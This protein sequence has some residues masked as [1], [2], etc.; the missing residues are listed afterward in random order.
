LLQRTVRRS[1]S[2]FVIAGLVLAASGCASASATPTPGDSTEA[3]PTPTSGGLADPN[4]APLPSA[5]AGVNDFL[6][7]LQD[8]DLDAVGA[9]AYDLVVM[10]YSSDGR[11]T[12]EFTREQVSALRNSPGGPKILLAYLSIGEAEDYRYY[13]QSD[14]EEGNPAWLE[15]ENP[16]WPGNLKVRYWEPGWQS[17]VFDYAGRILAAGFDGAYLDIVDAYEY[18]ADRGRTTAAQEMPELVAALAAFFRT[19]NPDFY[20]FPQNAPEL[21]GLAPGYLDA[22]DGIGQEDIYYGHNSDDEPTSSSVTLE[23]ERHLDRLRGAGKLVL[24]VD[25]A[26]SPAHVSD[27]YATARSKGYVPLATIRSLDRLTVNPGHEPD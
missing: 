21:A 12:G 7:Q 24:T 8:L 4:T 17:V 14:W 11:E 27:A 16:D 20:I 10:D 2:L 23:L 26:T 1:G 25:Y 5:L 13:W 3:N 9:T 22:V 18:F 15:G 6:Y 19:R